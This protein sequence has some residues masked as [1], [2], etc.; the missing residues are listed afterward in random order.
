MTA[1][2]LYEQLASES[3]SSFA[4][5][6][7]VTHST[8]TVN[9]CL[10]CEAYLY[11]GIDAFRRIE[12]FDFQ[13]RKADLAGRLE[14]NDDYHNN[15]VEML[16]R[17]LA[18]APQ[19]IAWANR[20]ISSGMTVDSLDEFRQCVEE[21]TAIVGGEIPTPSA[22]MALEQEAISEY[23]HGETV[24]GFPSQEPNN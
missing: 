23:Q 21:A 22:I 20:C 8:I 14:L 11:A 17:W 5:T 15:I 13:L 2:T 16:R 10:D 3:V 24:E 1:T 19:A 12:R 18:P 4:A 9:D 6:E 7:P